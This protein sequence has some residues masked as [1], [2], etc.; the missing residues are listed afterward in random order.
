MMTEALV[1]G[2]IAAA[3]PRRIEVLD[4]DRLARRFMWFQRSMRLY[5][6]V[7]AYGVLAAVFIIPIAMVIS[8]AALPGATPLTGAAAIGAFWLALL[9]LCYAFAYL[10]RRG[11]AGSRRAVVLLSVGFLALYLV[12]ELALLAVLFLSDAPAENRNQIVALQPFMLVFVTLILLGVVG[13]LR[14]R[15]MPGADAGDWISW[16]PTRF[17]CR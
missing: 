13:F 3:A 1:E 4:I 15:R 16:F 14:T 11:M 2:G 10:Y 12:L 17:C 9:A 8:F 5:R 6:M 7:L